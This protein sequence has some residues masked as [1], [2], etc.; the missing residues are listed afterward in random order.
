MSFNIFEPFEQITSG[1]I[2]DLFTT[3]F[4]LEIL[5]VLAGCLFVYLLLNKATNGLVDLL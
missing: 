5:A 2:G 4:G 1:F 3:S